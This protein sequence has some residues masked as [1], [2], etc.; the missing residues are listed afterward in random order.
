MAAACGKF[1]NSDE[2]TLALTPLLSSWSV[3]SCPVAHFRSFRFFYTRADCIPLPPSEL[4]NRSA[5]FFFFSKPASRP[6][7]SAIRHGSGG[8]DAS[9]RKIVR[10]SA[11]SVSHSSVHEAF[12]CS[13]TGRSIGEGGGAR[14]IRLSSLSLSLPISSPFYVLFFLT[15]SHNPNGILSNI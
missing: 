11:V 14:R 2:L 7:H 4:A 5:C 15:T 13:T 1:G 6:A 10:F 8:S 12:A 9:P 3:L